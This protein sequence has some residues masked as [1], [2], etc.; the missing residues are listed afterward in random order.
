MAKGS[1]KKVE[2]EEVVKKEEEVLTPE[3][4][5]VINNR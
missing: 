5:K 3:V 1:A 2:S 4:V